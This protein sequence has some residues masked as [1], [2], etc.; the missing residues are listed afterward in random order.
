MFS[1]YKEESEL[2]AVSESFA[3]SQSHMQNQALDSGSVA[4]RPQ[5]L[6]AALYFI[7]LSSQCRERNRS[8]TQDS[9][10]RS[11]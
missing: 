11:L 3:R 10:M 9:S 4:P 6:T 8:T 2:Q 7:T 5:L 1:I